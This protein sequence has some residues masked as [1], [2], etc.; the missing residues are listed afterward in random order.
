MENKQWSNYRVETKKG[1]HKDVDQLTEDE[2]KNQLC[3]QLDLL[4]K[5]F[6]KIETLF[7]LGVSES[8]LA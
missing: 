5:V 8:F 7:D 2:A 1:V 4:Q 3:I 6:N